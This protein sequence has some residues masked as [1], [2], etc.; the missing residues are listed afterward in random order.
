[1]DNV[2]GTLVM[3]TRASKFVPFQEMKIQEVVSL[4]VLSFLLERYSR[5]LSS[6][7]VSLPPPPPPPRPTKFPSDIFLGR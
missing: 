1:M 7:T 3:Q 6:L 4:S 5:P 2:K